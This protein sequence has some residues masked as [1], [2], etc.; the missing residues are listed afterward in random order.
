MSA[1]SLEQFTRRVGFP[2]ALSDAMKKLVITVGVQRSGAD[3]HLW[4]KK[5]QVR[6]CAQDDKM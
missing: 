4:L 5:T 6:H 1:S 2:D 3:L